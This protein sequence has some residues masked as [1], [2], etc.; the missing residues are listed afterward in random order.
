[1]QLELASNI[2]LMR[3]Q[4]AL[5][6]EQLAEVLGV[7]VGAVHKWEAG[8]SVPELNM[9]VELADFFDVSVDAL[10]GYKLKDNRIGTTLRRLS[11]YSRSMDPEA[12]TEAEKALKKYPHS[13]DI[14]YLCAQLFFVY[15]SAAKEK[16]LIRRSLT[17]QE[18]A[19]ALLSQNTC[20]EINENTISIDMAFSYGLLGEHEKAL[21][22]MKKHN[23]GGLY[24]DQIGAYLILM[25]RRADEAKPYLSQAL[26]NCMGTLLNTVMA[27][28]LVFDMSG[29]PD[30]ARDILHWELDLMRGL[31]REGRIDY[32][33]K[34]HAEINA[35]LAYIQLKSGREDEARTLMRTVRQT[36]LSFDA[37]PDYSVNSIRYVSG[38]EQITAHDILGK[39]AAE[40]VEF[41]LGSLS[42]DA[43][44][45]LWKEINENEYSTVKR[46]E[47][48]QKPQL[49]AG[50]PR[51]AGIGAGRDPVQL[52]RELLSAGD[53]R[54]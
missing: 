48:I 52:C 20:S 11:E 2:R 41:L 10:L 21:E 30:S 16:A 54:Q 18:T 46:R 1:M 42:D 51:C 39:T 6:Q 26:V 34:C 45:K 5:T 28:T 29:Q 7:T 12:L 53:Q 19:L 37:A 9:I 25:L 44:L 32:L 35:L 22:L 17:L 3:K 14:V 4:R 33:D 8:L 36:A 40:S 24:S 31:K 49:S 13:F 27:F 15:G 23:V 50:I 47:C 38:T 43:G